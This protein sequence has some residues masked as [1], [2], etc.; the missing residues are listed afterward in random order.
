MDKKKLYQE[1]T[2]NPKNVRFDEICRAAELF[3]FRF[4]GGK[5]SHRIFVR[6]GVRELLNFQ[7]VKGY[8]KSY[9]VKQFIQVIEKYNLIKE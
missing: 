1:L 2:T 8:A 7:N 3:G 5:G 6:Q 9:Q 4:R